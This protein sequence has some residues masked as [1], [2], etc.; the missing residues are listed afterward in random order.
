MRG[1]ATAWIAQ[2]PTGH[3]SNP[4]K[5]RFSTA[6][7]YRHPTL[8]D[9]RRRRPCADTKTNFSA[10][11]AMKC[12]STYGDALL[13]RFLLD[14]FEWI[15]R[16]AMKTYVAKA[17]QMGN[18]STYLALLAEKCG[19]SLDS[20]MSQRS[21]ASSAQSHFS[22]SGRRGG[23]ALSSLYARQT[24]FSGQEAQSGDCCV[25]SVAT[26]GGQGKISGLRLRGLHAPLCM[27]HIPPSS[28][29]ASLKVPTRKHRPSSKQQ[30]AS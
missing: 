14:G 28:I 26:S 15:A 29:R 8:Q 11:I 9:E 17:A 30:L 12:P 23:F 2:R 4:G 16:D 19:C 20:H 10:C 1:R 27:L 24:L 22:S 7:T 13:A 5:I 18:A 25:H 3:L 6:L 21:F